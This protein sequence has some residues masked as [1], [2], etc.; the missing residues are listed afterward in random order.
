VT[1]T[2]TYNNYDPRAIVF[3]GPLTAPKMF[4]ADGLVG[5]FVYPTC[6][7]SP[8]TCTTAATS[9]AVAAYSTVLPGLTQT[10]SYLTG[11]AAYTMNGV[12]YIAVTRAD[13]MWLW[14]QAN[15]GPYTSSTGTCCAV[16]TAGACCWGNGNAPVAV[17]RA[18][19]AFRGLAVAPFSTS[20]TSCVGCPAGES[21]RGVQMNRGIPR[22]P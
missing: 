15:T 22:P 18:N 19:Y 16:T 20:S 2:V 8:V 7:G 12:D 3:V 10:T 9:T 6:S 11:A 5:L 17:P 21:P 1:P 14:P 13:G 4:V